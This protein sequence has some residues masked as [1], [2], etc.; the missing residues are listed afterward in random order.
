M[1]P[2]E[3]SVESLLDASD[4]SFDESREDL[5]EGSMRLRNGRG[6]GH[7]HNNSRN[8]RRTSR[9]SSFAKRKSGT[10]LNNQINNAV[11]QVRERD[12]RKVSSK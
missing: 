5:L 11:Q 3:E 12:T 10:R 9:R 7:A 4:L 6:Y 1:A 8:N 2:V